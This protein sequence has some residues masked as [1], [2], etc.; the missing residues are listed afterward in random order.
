MMLLHSYKIMRV[1]RSF[2]NPEWIA[3]IAETSDDIREVFPY[4]NTIFKNAVYTLGVPSLNFKMESGFISL[5]PRE[6]GVRQVLSEEDAIKVLD[7]LKELINDIWE[8]RESI[9]PIYERKGEIKYAQS[10]PLVYGTGTK[11]LSIAI[12][13]S[14]ATFPNTNV[15]LGVIACFMIQM[16]LASVFYKVIPRILRKSEMS[17]GGTS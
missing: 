7:Y 6:I 4:L 1:G 13:L 10:I 17:Q 14:L 8:R 12:A 15:V 2:C 5:M 11:N 16:P 9:T 3:V